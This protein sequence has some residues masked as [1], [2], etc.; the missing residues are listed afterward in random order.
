MFFSKLDAAERSARLDAFTASEPGKTYIIGIAEQKVVRAPDKLSTLGL[1]SC[2]GLVL[3]DSLTKIGGM[4]HIMLPTAPPNTP[5][6]NKA[7]YADTAVPELIRLLAAA[8]AQPRRLTAKLAGGAHM[9]RTAKNLDFM[10]VGDRNVEQCKKTLFAHSIPILAE[11]TGG[12]S[13]RSIEF[14]CETGLLK[15]RTVSPKNIKLL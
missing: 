5:D 10:N 14:C 4:V 1:G 11:D 9:F 12:S 8:G 6:L 7:K 3:Y 13:G 15:V 2:V